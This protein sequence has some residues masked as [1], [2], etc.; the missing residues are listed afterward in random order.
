MLIEDPVDE[1]VKAGSVLG[2]GE[3][4]DGEAEEQQRYG[5]K[6]NHS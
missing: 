5:G 3:A 2:M 1:S 4:V 6:S